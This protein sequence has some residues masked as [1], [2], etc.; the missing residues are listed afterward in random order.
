MN[1]GD[2]GYLGAGLG[3]AVALLAIYLVWLRALAGRADRELR[4]LRSLRGERR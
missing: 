3:S 2:L 4:W 1:P